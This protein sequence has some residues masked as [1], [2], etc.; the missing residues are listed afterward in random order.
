[1]TDKIPDIKEL[2]KSIKVPKDGATSK[3]HVI[4]NPQIKGNEEKAN[5]NP[6]L[7]AKTISAKMSAKTEGTLPP[8]IRSMTGK[9]T[10]V[11]HVNRRYVPAHSVQRTLQGRSLPTAGIQASSTRNEGMDLSVRDSRSPEEKERIKSNLKTLTQKIRL[12]QRANFTSTGKPRMKAEE[13]NEMK[14]QDSQAF[15]IGPVD[16]A[17]QDPAK[18]G[19]SLASKSM[20]TLKQDLSYALANKDAP[21]QSVDPDGPVKDQLLGAPYNK[22]KDLSVDD[23]DVINKEIGVKLDA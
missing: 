8:K 2:I 14:T 3:S 19:R 1:M 22:A 9:K 4:I 7:A 20:A 18:F 10:A 15:P 11:R 12:K 5:S 6:T 23:V 17:P 16:D 21:G 13:V